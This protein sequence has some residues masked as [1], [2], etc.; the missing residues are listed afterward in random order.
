MHKLLRYV[1][2]TT[3][4]STFFPADGKVD[5]V[6]AYLDGD[7]GCD[8]LD[9]KS[10]AGG[11]VMVAGC[12][13]HSHSRCVGNAL[14]SGESEIMSLSETLKESMLIKYN[15]C[16]CGMGD[17][18]LILHTDA[19]VARQFAHRLGVGKMKHLD[20]RLM[21]VQ[22]EMKKGTFTLRKIPRENNPS[23]SL[24][25]S[26]STS[27]LG[28]FLPM[29]GVFPQ[30]CAVGAA[31]LVKA[32]AGGGPK[33]AAM[34]LAYMANGA[35]GAETIGTDT[36]SHTWSSVALA[37]MVIFAVTGMISSGMTLVKL[38]AKSLKKIKKDASTQ[39][40]VEEP[41]IPVPLPPHNRP[42]KVYWTANGQKYHL[43]QQCWSI[44]G[45]QLGHG[46]LCN[47]CR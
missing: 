1:K 9:R 26:P 40:D 5:R 45:K 29:M 19:S 20:I 32:V 25:H 37:C 34:I 18:P 47:I 38:L 7:W 11:L 2:G 27:E 44:A 21:W 17:L 3:E 46:D 33:L 12:R 13:V 16:F 15:L 31:E 28:K 23:D 30:G 22:T 8:E 42:T 41:A 4:L 35:N 10:V 36:E 24:T 39:T 43:N 6:E 14:S